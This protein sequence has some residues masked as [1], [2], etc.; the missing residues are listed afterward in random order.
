LTPEETKERKAE[1]AERRAIWLEEQKF[2]DAIREEERQAEAEA[3]AAQEA[4]TNE[5]RQAEISRIQQAQQATERD[6]QQR[7]ALRFAGIKQ[8]VMSP[9]AIKFGKAGN[10]RWTYAF[11][12]DEHTRPYRLNEFPS[13]EQTRSFIDDLDKWM[14]FA[15]VDPSASITEKYGSSVD[16]AELLKLLQA[17]EY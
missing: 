6:K 9:G 7:N 4:K 3:H 2:N 10:G 13:R 17:L 11:N 14:S 1:A 15:S 12:W 8:T 16:W 5:L